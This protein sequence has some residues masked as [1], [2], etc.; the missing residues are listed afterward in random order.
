M[1]TLF[2]AMLTPLHGFSREPN[3]KRI[4][5]QS[6][7]SFLCCFVLIGCGNQR[8]AKEAT[9]KGCLF[10]N[11]ALR[12][13]ELLDHSYIPEPPQVI[14]ETARVANGV[15]KL[16]SKGLRRVV[17]EDIL[18]AY[19]ERGVV[20]EIL[21]AGH[22]VWNRR[23]FLLLASHFLAALGIPRHRR[24]FHRRREHQGIGELRIY[25]VTRIH[26]VALEEPIKLDCINLFPVSIQEMPG[27]VHVPVVPCPVEAGVPSP[28]EPSLRI[29]YVP[30]EAAYV[31][32]STGTASCLPRR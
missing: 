26:P 11:C 8:T 25:K 14:I 16:V 4:P 20:Q 30:E 3:E 12:C 31:P 29:S 6:Q 18:H 1:T 5:C 9:S 17:T 21:P 2:M 22:S 13:L 23:R 15:A 27:P 28:F 32:L 7:F 24:R 10:V 19:C